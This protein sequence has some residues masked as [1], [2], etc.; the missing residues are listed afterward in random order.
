MEAGRRIWADGT[1]WGAPMFDTVSDDYCTVCVRF[2]VCDGLL[3][4]VACGDLVA[5]MGDRA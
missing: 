3:R 2:V 5:G 1:T 4:L